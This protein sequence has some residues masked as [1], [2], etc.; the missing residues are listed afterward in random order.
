MY[1]FTSQQVPLLEEKIRQINT[2]YFDASTELVK[3]KEY[4]DSVSQDRKSLLSEKS[5]IQN[6]LERMRR[7]NKELRKSLE[8][9][10]PRTSPH[11]VCMTIEDTVHMHN[12]PVQKWVNV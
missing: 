10:S 5:K 3:L 2:K 4:K 8:N 7:E 11:R 1:Y 12:E 9:L 6:E